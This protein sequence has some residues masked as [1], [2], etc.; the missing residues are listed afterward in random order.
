MERLH[1]HKQYSIFL[2][3][4]LSGYNLAD[5]L[6]GAVYIVLMSRRGIDPLQISIV[7]AVSS[8][9]LAIFD[10][11]SGNLSDL[12]GRKKLAAIGF[13]TW[14]AGLCL[15]AFASNLLLFIVSAVIMSLGVALISGSLQAWYIDKLD[16][17]GM[18]DYKN[19]V[20]PRLNGF[21]SAFAIVG[22]LLATLSS[23]IHLYLP[24]AIAGVVAIGLSIYVWF[25]FGDNYGT[26]TEDNIFKEVYVTSV[27]FARNKLMRFVLL[28][29]IFSHAALLAFLLSW[30]VYGVNE[31]KLP[32]GYLGVLLIVFMAVMSIS[33]FF[34]SFLAK[35][36]VSAIKIISWGTFISAA[37][38]LLA[39]LFPNPIIFVAG[40]ILFEFGLGME[41]SSFGAWIQ[42]LIP[43]SK[44]AT[45]SSGLSSLKSLAGFFMALL[46]GL[47]SEHMGYSLIWYLAALSLLISI[48]VLLY[49]N[50]MFLR[51]GTV[52]AEAE[53]A[54]I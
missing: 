54:T 47:I 53:K 7:F 30:Q 20:L 33:A 48:A 45:F 27:D 29:S 24:V 35:R 37:G 9:S 16:D 5:K 10:Y 39:G 51:A 25:R 44:R 4:M 19:V 8:L 23:N 46:L 41:S 43:R 17:L 12:Y 34:S 52:Q 38:L 21:V 40:L 2:G 18:M 50:A 22:A 32:V 11:P 3:I 14:G 13:F 15:F 49:L 1:A 26:R 28:K 42:D 31:L 36:K 6:Y